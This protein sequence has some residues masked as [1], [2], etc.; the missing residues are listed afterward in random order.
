MTKKYQEKETYREKGTQPLSSLL[1]LDAGR[2]ARQ[3]LL[4]CS[5][6]QRLGNCSMRCSTFRHPCRSPLS[7]QLTC[8]QDRKR[9]ACGRGVRAFALVTFW[10]SARSQYVLQGG[11]SKTSYSASPET[12]HQ[13]TL[14]F[15]LECRPDRSSWHQ[16]AVTL[17]RVPLQVES[18]KPTRIT[19]RDS[20]AL[21]RDHEAW[22]A[23]RGQRQVPLPFDPFREAGLLVQTVNLPSAPRSSF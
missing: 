10:R 21:P 20:G 9:H 3:L 1:I 16:A 22:R 15:G 2:D 11:E 7:G 23:H 12:S 4:R 18:D 13:K 17:R 6:F 19:P 5:N 8:R 14:G